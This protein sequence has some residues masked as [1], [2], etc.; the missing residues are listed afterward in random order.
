[1]TSPRPSQVT[2]RA[3]AT[4]ANLGPG[5]DTLGLALNL[6]NEFEVALRDDDVLTVRCEGEGADGVP[7]DDNHLVV[8]AMR[9]A[10]ERAGEKLPGLD[11]SCVNRV[12]HARGLGSS[13][14]AIVG[15]IA[16]AAALMGRTGP[17]GGPDRDWIYQ[18]AADMEGHPDN[19]APCVFGGYTSPIGRTVAGA[20]SPARG[21][22]DSAGVVCARLD[23]V[24]RAGPRVAPRNRRPRGRILQRGPCS[25]HDRGRLWPSRGP[26]RSDPGSTARGLSCTGDA[27][28]PGTGPRL[29]RTREVACRGLRCRSHSV[30]AVFD[31]DRRGGPAFTGNHPADRFDPS[32]DG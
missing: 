20:C 31:H 29:T 27:A 21:R 14:S 22:K 11:L 18:I 16:A 5:F 23:H 17:D 12:P 13:S 15:G 24:H 8:R 1:M 3:P 4:S 19:V 28:Y 6:H 2:V 32:E 26:V 9:E 30:G 10:C 25:A 7:L